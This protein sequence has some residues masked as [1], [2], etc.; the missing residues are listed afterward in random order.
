MMKM[1]DGIG[2]AGDFVDLVQRGFYDG[3]GALVY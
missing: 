1:S 3:P 2:E